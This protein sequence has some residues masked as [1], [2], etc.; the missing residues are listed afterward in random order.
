MIC[1][2][3]LNDD[4]L[5]VLNPSW[6]GSTLIGSLF[7]FDQLKL[8]EPNGRFC[9]DILHKL[10]PG[11]KPDKLVSLLEMLELCTK[12]KEDAKDEIEFPCLCT[13]SDVSDMY[14][15]FK[16]NR[17]DY[18]HGGV[19]IVAPR[20]LANQLIHV[21]PKVQ[22]RL[23]QHRRLVSTN[24]DAISLYS[25]QHC[26]LY[27]QGNLR[28]LVMMTADSQ[29]IDVR[30]CGPCGERLALYYFKEEVTDI[31]YSVLN[32]C[33]PGLRL[34]HHLLSCVELKSTF[35]MVHAYCP[36]DIHEAQMCSNVTVLLPGKDRINER[37]CDLVGFGSTE[38]FSQL[39]SGTRLH[40]AHLTL[41]ARRGLSQVVDP[42]DATGRDWCLLAVSLGLAGE[43]PKLEEAESPTDAC[44]R[45]W[46][47][48][49]D[50]TASVLIE[51]LRGLGRQDAV[52]AL[53]SCLPLF[54]RSSDINCVEPNGGC[55]SE[56]SD[57]TPSSITSR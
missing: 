7:S 53:F 8:Y 34:E 40:I 22:V 42:P 24:R 16:Q 25:F 48:N 49:Q 26:S 23:R 6:L 39:V 13:I 47:R 12:C 1:I 21:F 9:S 45:L 18:V 38:I 36:K 30:S 54:V 20:G 17:S 10:H 31:V 51:K 50:A 57:H 33:C 27:I 29:A 15:M 14:T 19:R 37:I 44:I 43:L 3:K 5:V 32:D 41:E 55:A 56:I 4:D 52:D 35:G 11:L 28:V 2:E 46:S